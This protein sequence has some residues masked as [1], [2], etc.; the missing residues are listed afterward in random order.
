[1]ATRNPREQHKICVYPHAFYE[2]QIL[3]IIIAWVSDLTVIAVEYGS[4]WKEIIIGSMTS[5]K[6]EKFF[7]INL[8]LKLCCSAQSPSPQRRRIEV[9]WN[10]VHF[11]VFG[12]N[13]L[14]VILWRHFDR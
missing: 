9:Y 4:F 8:V 11:R 13:D 5:L 10:P 2:R 7:K 6:P 1:M 3:Y 14:R 12:R